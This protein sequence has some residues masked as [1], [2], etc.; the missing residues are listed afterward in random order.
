MLKL[1]AVSKSFGPVRAVDGVSL[2]VGEGEM[3]GVIGRSGAGK[4][5][6]LRLINR[7]VEPDAGEISWNGR[8]VSDLR[9]R[10]LLAWRA[11]CGMIFQQFH[12]V[13]RFDALTNVLLGSLRRRSLPA[14][15]C[16]YFPPQERR[17]AA[18]LLQD[19]DLSDK[20]LTPV[21]Q[22]SGGQQQRVAIARALLQEVR[23]LLADEPVAS[24]DPKS[25]RGVMEALVRLN[26]ERGVTVITSLHTIEFARAY[27]DRIIGMAHGRIIFDGT[28]EQLTGSRIGEIYGLEEPA[29]ALE[30][31]AS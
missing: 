7:L 11:Q 8:V 27:C 28:A 20:A 14:I 21:A 6:L 22:L 25:G 26:R 16:K 10:D 24:L 12:L 31:D 3:V 30:M 4:S 9:G 23:I 2:E 1:H 29:A 13:G 5:T 18:A 19:L 15:L 17:R